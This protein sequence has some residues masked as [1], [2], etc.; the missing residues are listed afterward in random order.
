MP[1]APEGVVLEINLSGVVAIVGNYGSGKTE[2]SI[3][4][5][6]SLKN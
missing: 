5:D 6:Y 1:F 4:L 3:N 2:V